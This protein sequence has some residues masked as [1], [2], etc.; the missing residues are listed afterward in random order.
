[1][2]ECELPPRDCIHDCATLIRAPESGVGYEDVPLDDEQTPETSTSYVRRDV[3]MLVAYATAKVACDAP[4]AGLLALGDMS[5]REGRTPGTAKGRVRHPAT[6]HVDGRDIDMAYF[7]TGTVDQHLR[8][9]CEHRIAG[10]N[11][12]HCVAPPTTLDAWR[13][14]LLVG[15]LFES[16]RVRVVGVDGQVAPLL[17]GAIGAACAF[18][19]IER[20]ACARV[21]LGFEIVDEGR[22]WF[23]AHHNHLHVSW[24]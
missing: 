23:Y 17:L 15:A 6:T 24:R 9:V 11:Q 22:G 20:D 2:S 10:E 7:Q 1:V 4:G 19:K 14:A 13:T 5:D 8:P 3:M 12:R 21:S 16:T 18:G